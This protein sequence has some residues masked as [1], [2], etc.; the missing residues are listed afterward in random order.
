MVHASW[1]KATDELVVR[2]SLC[3]HALEHLGRPQIG[4][5][6]SGD[7]QAILGQGF[8]GQ[9]SCIGYTINRD[10]VGLEV[11]D[12]QN[13]RRD[14]YCRNFHR[15]MG[16]STPKFRYSFSYI[17]VVFLAASG[18]NRQSHHFGGFEL[19]R[20]HVVAHTRLRHGLVAAK[21]VVDHGCD[22]FR[23]RL[24]GRI[25]THNRHLTCLDG[26]CQSHLRHRST[27]AR[28]GNHRRLGNEF[29][30]RN[31]VGS[32]IESV[33]FGQYVNFATKDTAAFVD[34]AHVIAK[35]IDP[36]ALRCRCRTTH[37]HEHTPVDAVF[38]NAVLRRILGPCSQAHT[39]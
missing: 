29:F 26:G 24:G 32:C 27:H 21:A 30:K 3:A 4:D 13:L 12:F 14:I 2:R 28:N 18:F 35:T 7:V 36:N 16:C 23:Q 19:E 6:K 15:Q 20:V 1:G 17:V 5:A 8:H 33:V 39:S 25:R 31:F 11:H 9:N 38:V 34:A 22:R 10:E 37:V